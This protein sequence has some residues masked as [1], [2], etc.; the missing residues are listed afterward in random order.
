VIF[1]LNDWFFEGNSRAIA[2]KKAEVQ[3]KKDWIYLHNI[4]FKH[5]L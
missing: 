1:A 5:T 3:G 4:K 2:R